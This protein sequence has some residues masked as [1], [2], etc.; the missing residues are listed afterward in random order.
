MIQTF[1]ERKWFDQLQAERTRVIGHAHLELQVIIGTSLQRVTGSS[2][3]DLFVN[4][5]SG[6]QCGCSVT[7]VKTLSLRFPT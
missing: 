5:R 2:E 6:G 7:S 1:P 4:V 3:V